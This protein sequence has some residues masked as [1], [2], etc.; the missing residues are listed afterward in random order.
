MTKTS[1]DGL[2]VRSS[3][4]RRPPVTTPHQ[5]V[6]DIQ[7]APKLGASTEVPN[8]PKESKQSENDFLD[9]TSQD[10]GSALEQD[11]LGNI[12]GSMDDATWSELLD[13]FAADSNSGSSDLGLQRRQNG[14]ATLA[15]NDTKPSR[16]AK[17][18]AKSNIRLPKKRHF[19]IKH[20][21]ILTI[22]IV[23]VSLCITGFV[24]GDSLISR[25]TNGRSGF[26]DTIGALVSNE[27]PF[28]TDANGRTNVL[29]FGTEGYD[30]EGS[31]GD[32]T[33]A[34]AQLTD[35]IMVISFDQKTQDVALLSIPRD[36]K[37]SMAC[38]VGKINEV[39]TCYSN[40]GA[41]DEAGAQALMKQLTEVLGIEFQYWA[42]VNWG[43]LV[44]IVDT[45]GGVTVTLDE[46][47]NDKYYTGV[48][49]EA[50]VPTNL[51][52]IQAVAL[53]RARHG[54]VGGDFTRG[55]SQQK[56]VEGIVQKLS[57]NGVNI[58]EA[59]GLL[60][61]LGDNFRSNFSSDNIKAGVRL[62]SSFN[63]GSIRN[64]TLTDYANNIYY[65]RTANIGGYSYVVPN[66]GEGNYRHIH[67]LVATM[68][69]SNPA[70]RE[71]A[72][73]A[74]YNGTDADGMASAEQSRLEADGY[75][76]S[77]IGNTGTGTCPEK[78]CVYSLTED[79][80]A[81]LD[82]LANRYNTSVLPAAELPADIAPGAADFVIVIGQ[83]LS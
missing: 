15:E 75:A 4:E 71:G 34:G 30:M 8:A 66:E 7:P 48:I 65:V 28:E 6:Q 40:D 10:L 42:H 60:N 24:W 74:V 16:R 44:D 35:S 58:S 53:A 19:R 67:E 57:T 62:A 45:L 17:R 49:I 14:T 77:E 70:V 46:D 20:P 3:R 56:I 9:V 61:I 22:F 1:I 21:V 31:S 68:F 50:G 32:G 69:S 72:Q 82:A 13:G 81:T 26:W 43:S 80:P 18:K 55:N 39:Y 59:L 41:N 5:V 38:Q 33:H 63:P 37:V 52:G 47:I 54:T 51:T 79:M 12:S 78:Y 36:L 27:V 29:V 73:I 64:V 83:K 23:L 11:T 25:L 76:V 2:T